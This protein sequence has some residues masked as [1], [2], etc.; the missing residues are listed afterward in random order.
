MRCWKLLGLDCIGTIHCQHYRHTHNW[1]TTGQVTLF[2]ADSK[3]C[4]VYLE[5]MSVQNNLLSCLADFQF[6]GDGP[7]IAERTTELEIVNRDVIVDRLDPELIFNQ[8]PSN[9][10]A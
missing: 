3:Y 10:Y 1:Q 8:Y 2:L 5:L 7:L 9:K 6:D 4:T